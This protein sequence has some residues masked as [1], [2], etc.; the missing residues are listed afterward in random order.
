MKTLRFVVKFTSLIVA[1]LSCFDRVIFSIACPSPTGRLSKASSIASS[2]SGGGDF[3]AFADE[4]SKTLVEFAKGL[5]QV[6]GA[7]YRFLQGHHRKGQARRRDE[8]DNG[9][10]SMG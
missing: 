9:P 10:S 2:R 5:A 3:M 6:A 8:P 1:V 7:E 4:Q